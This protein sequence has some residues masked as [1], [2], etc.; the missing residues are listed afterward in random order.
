MFDERNSCKDCGQSVNWLLCTPP[1]KNGKA[2]HNILAA[3]AFA[4]WRVFKVGALR[5]FRDGL[6]D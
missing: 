4:N 1:E 5:Q 2:N 3:A 6:W